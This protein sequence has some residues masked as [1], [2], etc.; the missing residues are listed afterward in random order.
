MSSNN[1][2]IRRKLQF[3]GNSSYVLTLPKSWIKLVKLDK[4]SEVLI[5]ELPDKTLR[6]SPSQEVKAKPKNTEITLNVKESDSSDEIIR[7]ILASYLASKNKII[8]QSEKKPLKPAMVLAIN[9]I[10]QKLWGAEIIESTSN[11]I[12]IH[13]ALDPKQLQLNE[14]IRKS[15]DTA[16]Y[17]FETALNS[18]FEHDKVAAELVVNNE[19]TLDKLYYLALRQ[20]YYASSHMLFSAEIGIDPSEIIDYHLLIKNIE[21]IG[22][23]CE[24]IVSSYDAE[25]INKEELEEVANMS[26]TACEEA[27]QSF[28][29]MDSELA[30]SATSQ[31]GI[32]ISR[33]DAIESIPAEFNLIKSILR[34]ADYASDIG[35]LTI[36]RLIAN[37]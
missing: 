19:K 33:V 22:D 27:I 11:Q 32:I 29:K 10:I 9:E 28:L 26:K 35:E 3:A 13:D 37:Y 24:Q 14:I 25:I 30:Q 8:L 31:K 12:I 6:I 18:I 23:H 34:I 20:L 1:Q 16:R 5:D 2:P 36:N 4:N 15:W 17:M 21:R 7:L